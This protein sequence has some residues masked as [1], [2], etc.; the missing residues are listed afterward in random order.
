MP[1]PADYSQTSHHVC[2]DFRLK[3]VPGRFRKLPDA[4]PADSIIPPSPLS[5]IAANIWI[6]V[7][8][9]NTL[10]L[11]LGISGR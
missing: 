11:F 7:S 8:A 5:E 10:A 3:A 4:A 2:T 6:R 9:N 1:Y